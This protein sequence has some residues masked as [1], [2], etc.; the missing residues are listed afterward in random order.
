MVGQTVDV[1]A[2]G[3]QNVVSVNWDDNEFL[4]T[5]QWTAHAAEPSGIYF[6]NCFPPQRNLTCTCR[7]DLNRCQCEALNGSAVGRSTVWI[8][9]GTCPASCLGCTCERGDCIAIA[10]GATV[11]SE[12]AFILR[13]K[14]R[15]T[16]W[17]RGSNCSECVTGAGDTDTYQYKIAQSSGTFTETMMNNCTFE[18]GISIPCQAQTRKFHS[19]NRQG[20]WT[21]YVESGNVELIGST[22][23]GVYTANTAGIAAMAAWV[24]AMQSAHNYSTS[25]SA[26]N[27]PYDAFNTNETSSVA[28]VQATYTCPKG[29]NCFNDTFY[30]YTYVGVDPVTGSD[31]YCETNI[32][33]PIT[34]DS[35]T[36]SGTY[37]DDEPFSGHQESTMNMSEIGFGCNSVTYSK[38]GSCCNLE[39]CSNT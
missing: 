19:W 29:C 21:N 22:I 30:T 23:G 6:K 5:A 3:D 24:S 13:K 12:C 26:T 38:T 39:P 9:L 18:L 17:K 4:Y 11:E 36:E 32:L 25:S 35:Y 14:T 28:F 20:S 15:N 34:S 33:Y 1:G 27:C 16:T 31:V 2:G 7:T 8:K 10:G 37:N